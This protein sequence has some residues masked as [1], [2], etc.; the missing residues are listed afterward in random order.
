ME[1]IKHN[2]WKLR[3]YKLFRDLRLGFRI[4][5]E[6]FLHK[7]FQIKDLHKPQSTTYMGV[8]RNGD[9]LRKGTSGLSMKGCM[10]TILRNFHM[11]IA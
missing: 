11:T 4:Q 8:F 7:G 6:A 3:V 1:N 9:A 2:T 5:S 10:G